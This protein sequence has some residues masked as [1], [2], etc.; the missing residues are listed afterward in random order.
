MTSVLASTSPRRISIA[1]LVAWGTTL[2]AGALT[3]RLF[4]LSCP[5]HEVTGL[6]CPACGG[7][8]AIASLLQGRFVAA[9][10]YNALALALGLLA[11]PYLLLWKMGW[12][13][14]AGWKESWLW[15]H[16]VAL[17]VSGLLLWTVLRN[18]PGFTWFNTDWA[19]S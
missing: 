3:N 12:T 10:H 8:R 5:F 14:P 7:T 16:R 13:V 11:V 2:V 15:Q 6:D 18:L 19:H 9:L 17:V 4:G 1:P